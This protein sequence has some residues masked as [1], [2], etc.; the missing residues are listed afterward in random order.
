MTPN[1]LPIHIDTSPCPHCWATF[2]THHELSCPGVDM[3]QVNAYFAWRD[4][5]WA[6]RD[7]RV[8]L[9]ARWIAAV[10]VMLVFALVWGW[11]A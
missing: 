8:E 10:V 9:A 5:R 3:E 2:G 6:Q 1:P 7:R 4:E 11:L